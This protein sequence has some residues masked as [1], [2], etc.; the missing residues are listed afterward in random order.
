MAH[1]HVGQAVDV[2]LWHRRGLSLFHNGYAA[3]IAQ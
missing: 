1:P 2:L 3:P